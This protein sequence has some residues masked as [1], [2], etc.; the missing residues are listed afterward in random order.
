MKQKDPSSVLLNATPFPGTS[1]VD[2]SVVND[3]KYF[4][5][6]RAI[7]AKGVTSIVSNEAPAKI[8]KQGNPSASAALAPPCRVPGSSK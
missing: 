3:T 4:Y 1:C 8:P 5:V 2:D 7:S 6:V